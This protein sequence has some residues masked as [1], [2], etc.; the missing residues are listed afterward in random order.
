MADQTDTLPPEREHRVPPAPVLLSDLTRDLVWPNLL[1][2]LSLG[3]HPVRLLLCYALVLL[4][5]H[6]F[7]LA[8]AYSG[9]GLPS[10][11]GL[12]GRVRAW[13]LSGM[14]L[15][16][17]VWAV[18]SAML[19]VGTPLFAWL[20]GAL[21]RSAAEDVAMAESAGLRA[22]GRDA[23]RKLPSLVIA[24]LGAPVVIAAAFGLLVG[25]AWLL[26]QSP[27]TEA[28]GVVA[29]A[30][31][32]A[33]GLFGLVA[34]AFWGLL[35]PVLA[36]AVMCERS[37]GIDAIQRAVAYSIGRPFRVVLYGATLWALVGLTT[38]LA[39]TAA[40][41]SFDAVDSI[42]DLRGLRTAEDTAAFTSWLILFAIRSVLLLPWA[43]GLSVL[44]CGGGA[45]YL[46]LRQVCDGQD[47]ADLAGSPRASS[48]SS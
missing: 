24:L 47:P 42:V 12:F 36:P 46:A 31:A 9:D 39:L 23:L 26:V 16:P 41:A 8:A 25:A 35:L 43:I 6:G 38:W 34:F 30:V 27:I 44:H 19:V 10:A 33:A 40:D 5:Y 11:L 7:A 20:G 1:R 22:H 29:A 48:S 4:C 37:D 3:L 14:A 17:G 2:A 15:G 28:L 13:V 21:G 32:T 18:L 45:A